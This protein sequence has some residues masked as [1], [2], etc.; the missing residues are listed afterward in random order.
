MRMPLNWAWKD[1]WDGT[2]IR[3]IAKSHRVVI[4]TFPTFT[5][6]EWLKQRYLRDC[7]WVPFLDY[8]EYSKNEALQILEKDF[9]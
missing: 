3:S 4:K 6:F 9:G 8:L 1:K 5:N 2:N 7:N